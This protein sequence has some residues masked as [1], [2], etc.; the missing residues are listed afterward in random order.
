MSTTKIKLEEPYKSDWRFGYLVTNR[1]NRKT[2][3]LYNSQKD[4]S[5]TQYARY[6]LAVSLGRYLND[7]EEVDHIDGDVTNNNL[8][9]L[10]ILSKW[11]NVYKSNKL[12]DVHLQCP[13]CAVKFTRSRKSLRGKLERA[14]NNLICCSRSCGGRFGHLNRKSKNL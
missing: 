12:P 1:E 5:S 6:L 10:Q 11:E 3:I 13:V 14:A 8:N 9:N 7:E 4:R 2:L